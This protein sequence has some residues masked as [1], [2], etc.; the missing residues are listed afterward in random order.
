MIITEIGEVG[1]EFNG[2]Q[3]MLR[4]S[5]YAMTQIGDPQE[6]VRVYASVMNVEPHPEQLADSLVAIYACA[7]EDLSALFGGH[8]VDEKGKVYFKTGAA[9]QQEAIILARS[10]LLHGVVGALPPEKRATPTAGSY[11]KEFDARQHAS[12]VV[13]HLGVSSKEAWQMTMTEIVGAMRAKFPPP[14]GPGGNAP[15]RE[16]MEETMAW[17]DQVLAARRAKK[18]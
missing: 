16:E 13:A 7:D 6:I 8:D 5:L 4:P 15:T 2:Q 14:K 18:G 12:I 9:T 10:L 11:T 3:F 1:L 17:H